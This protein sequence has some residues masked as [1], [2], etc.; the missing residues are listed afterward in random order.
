M[1]GVQTKAW[2]A[3]RGLL[4][5]ADPIIHPEGTKSLQRNHAHDLKEHQLVPQSNCSLLQ[6]TPH[7]QS[8]QW[9]MPLSSQGSE[10]PASQKAHRTHV[11]RQMPSEMQCWPHPSLTGDTGGW[12]SSQD[13]AAEMGITEASI[14]IEIYVVCR[15][16]REARRWTPQCCRATQPWHSGLLQ[17][18]QCLSWATIVSPKPHSKKKPKA[19]SPSD[20]TELIQTL[21]HSQGKLC[22]R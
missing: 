11:Q 16:A 22:M 1:A 19:F 21:S 17:T 15:T 7:L 5:L 20:L 10:K 3:A 13:H 8:C 4:I 9:R 18:Q 6:N 12:W 2:T 14:S